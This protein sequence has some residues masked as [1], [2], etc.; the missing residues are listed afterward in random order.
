V[1]VLLALERRDPMT[2]DFFFDRLK[3][4]KFDVQ[5][6]QLI[7][8]YDISL[9]SSQLTPRISPVDQI[10]RP[11]RGQLSAWDEN[12]FVELYSLELSSDD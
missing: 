10:T 2:N 4:E 1:K 6:V 3:E 11:K 8:R 9:L 12:D 5:K 7:D